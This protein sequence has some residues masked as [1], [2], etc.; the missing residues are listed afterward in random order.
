MLND[1]LMILK[2]GNDSFG[3]GSNF[4]AK[5]VHDHHEC[6]RNY[7]YKKNKS[8]YIK[9]SALERLLSY[10]RNKII[11][12][13]KPELASFLLDLYKQCYAAEG[14][15]ENDLAVYNF[16]NMC[17]MLQLRVPLNI[18]AKNNK[19]VVWKKGNMKYDVA[20]H[21]AKINAEGDDR[22]MWRCAS[23]LCNYIFAVQNKQICEP[24]TID[25]IVEGDTISPDSVKSFFKLLY[26]GNLSETE[27]LS[28]R[29]S[30]VI[31]SSAADAVF[32]CCAGK[33]T[34]GK[35][36]SL[37]FTL[38]SMTGSKKVLR[39]MN[40]YGHCAS[41]ETVRRVDIYFESTLNNFNSFIPDGI[42]TKP[43]L[44]TGTAWDNFD[45]NLKTRSGADTIHHTYGICYQT[46]K[47]TDE[48]ETEKSSE[49]H[50][51]LNQ[52]PNQL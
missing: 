11:A 41:S 40:R 7:L 43:N 48:I 35:E 46:I 14:G 12:E 9:D 31:V 28:S 6:K 23:K 16:Q 17:R 25:N 10:V 26:T 50:L 27:E 52:P 38:K 8:S 42:E 20:L 3:E 39:L 18:E 15:N 24:A 44:S 19:A 47:E 32:C 37:G 36:L 51:N 5:Q 4:V 33:L 1:E 34:P 49:I 13:N 2:I 45:I 21:L 22:M 29:I 30:P